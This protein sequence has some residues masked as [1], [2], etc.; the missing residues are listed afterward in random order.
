M[1]LP[2]EDV[3]I[4]SLTF[5]EQ[6][7]R[8]HPE[9]QLA[10][11]AASLTEFGQRRP[12]VI[13]DDGTVVAGNG[14]L[15]AAMTL[16]WDTIAVTRLPFDDEAKIR[17]FAIADNR[18]SDLSE[19]DID[20]LLDTLGND[21][22]SAL[23]DEIG[24]SDDELREL[25][26]VSEHPFTTARLSIDDLT[27]HPRNY[28]QHPD[29]QLDEI[30]ESIRSSGFYRNVVIARENVILAGHGVVE[31]VRRMGGTH[32]PAIRLDIDADDPR[33]LKVMTSDNEISNL[34][35]GD[36]R[37]LTELLR[38]I[39]HDAPEGLS[40]SG[41]DDEQLAALTFV[42]RDESEVRDK[43]AAREWVGM[44]EFEGGDD[45]F[46]L[47]V[48]F[49]SE[50]DRQRFV[51]ETDIHVGRA[52]EGSHAWSTRWPWVENDD[53]SSVAFVDSVEDEDE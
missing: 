35:I 30:A 11:L 8:M 32:V 6:N 29:A 36:D 25:E 1:S 52:A 9:R 48:L 17:A 21:D 43:D 53:H 27:A 13:T 46:K 28:Q 20:A 45:T 15:R 16:G 34:A 10:A 19:W 23:L 12:L 37:A 33:A 40:G 3:P 4:A 41:F 38:E 22:V 2:T 42:T 31:A 39:M 26:H 49:T 18:T 44:P 24:F 5:D 14:T 50:A 47:I 7:A 51:D